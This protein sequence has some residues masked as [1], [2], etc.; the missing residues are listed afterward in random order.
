MTRISFLL[1]VFTSKSPFSIGFG[2]QYGPQ[3]RKITINETE[4]NSSAWKFGITASIDVPIFNLF[5]R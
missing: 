2:A 3:V 5:S 1:V 4:L